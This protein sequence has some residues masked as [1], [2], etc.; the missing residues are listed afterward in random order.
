[1]T[2]SGRQKHMNSKAK[3]PGS[4]EYNIGGSIPVEDM[5]TIYAR[6]LEHAKELDKLLDDLLAEGAITSRPTVTTDQNA[7]RNASRV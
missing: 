5:Q 4:A 2:P 6:S 3:N 7:F 1:M